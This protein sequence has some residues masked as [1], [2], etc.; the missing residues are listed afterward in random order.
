MGK[1]TQE[2]ANQLEQ[3][4]LSQVQRLTA[5]RDDGV[6]ALALR[7][8]DLQGLDNVNPDWRATELLSVLLRLITHITDA[9]SGA[10]RVDDIALALDECTILIQTIKSDLLA[11]E[12]ATA[13]DSAFIPDIPRFSEAATAGDSATVTLLSKVTTAT[14]EVL[15]QASDSV[16]IP[17]YDSEI[18]IAAVLDSA[19]VLLHSILNTHLI[20]T[21]SATD[22]A[23]IILTPI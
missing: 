14:A 17:E 12:T 9:V 16:G 4:I 8:E 7:L 6:H 21:A 15:A 1:N 20:E 23:T 13:S 19:Q 11:A 2:A 22:S 5:V 18:E 3:R 10:I